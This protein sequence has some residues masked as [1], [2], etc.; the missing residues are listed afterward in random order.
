[1]RLRVANG[2]EERVVACGEVLQAL[3]G[4]GGVADGAL[5]DLLVPAVVRPATA[6]VEDLPD[7]GG[8]VARLS[9][10]P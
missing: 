2:E 3:D 10:E 4:D 1:M 7:G 6:R 9:E 8:A 5:G